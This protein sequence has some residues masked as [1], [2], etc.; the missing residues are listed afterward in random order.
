M[1]QKGTKAWWK[2]KVDEDRKAI[3]ADKLKAD[4]AALKV[5]RRRFSGD[6]RA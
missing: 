6:T 1:S 5:I 3:A 4:L 2:A